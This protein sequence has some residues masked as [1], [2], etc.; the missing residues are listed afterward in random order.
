MLL[1]MHIAS[2]QDLCIPQTVE[3]DMMSSRMMHVLSTV[4]QPGAASW[5]TRGQRAVGV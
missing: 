5:G 1:Y 4:L 2:K 3:C